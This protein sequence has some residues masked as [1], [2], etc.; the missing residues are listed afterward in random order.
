MKGEA[1]GQAVDVTTTYSDHKKTDFGIVL[2]YT[3]SVDLGMF[4]YVQKADKIEVNKTIDANI[5]EMPK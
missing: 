1:M 5:F 4:Q 2:A 3:K